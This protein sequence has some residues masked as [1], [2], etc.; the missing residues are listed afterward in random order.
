MLRGKILVENL[1]KK[2]YSFFQRFLI[3]AKVTS[4]VIFTI[5]DLISKWLETPN[6]SNYYQIKWFF[7]QFGKNWTRSTNYTRSSSCNF[8]NSFNLFPNC[9]QNRLIRLYSPVNSEGGGG[10]NLKKGDSNFFETAM[11]SISVK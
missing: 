9:T 1:E 11:I 8:V 6:P 2:T 3:C 7:V 10:I 5:Y 4:L